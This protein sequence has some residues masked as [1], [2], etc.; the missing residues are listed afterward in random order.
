ME[1]NLTIYEIKISFLA[2]KENYKE[3]SEGSIYKENNYSSEIKGTD[4]NKMVEMIKNEII[5]LGDTRVYFSPMV[6]S[7]SIDSIDGILLFDSEE[8]KRIDKKVC[9]EINKAIKQME[10]KRGF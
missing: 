9:Q 6:Y 5:T 4:I 1:K 3:I 2:L 8:T 7:Y 10:K